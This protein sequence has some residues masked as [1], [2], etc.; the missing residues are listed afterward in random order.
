MAN[1]TSWRSVKGNNFAR[2][3][4]FA[5]LR[6]SGFYDLKC[7]REVGACKNKTSAT[8]GALKQTKY[9]NL[10]PK[11]KKGKVTPSRS[12]RAIKELI[13]Q[14]RKKGNSTPLQRVALAKT[15]RKQ[16]PQRGATTTLNKER[17]R[18]TTK[19]GKTTATRLSAA[20][21]LDANRRRANKGVSVIKRSL[22]GKTVTKTQKK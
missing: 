21:R 8:V 1:K 7:K 18:S 11:S 12:E 2:K 4:W 15:L 20:A 5:R 22:L 16:G 14:G 10:S 6:A 19:G 13:K 3:M 9:A 17:A